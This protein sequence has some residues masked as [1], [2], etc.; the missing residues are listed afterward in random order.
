M[1]GWVGWE[2]GR[3]QSVSCQERSLNASWRAAEVRETL[4]GV[5]TN[6]NWVYVVYY[7]P[8]MQP[9]WRWHCFIQVGRVNSN[10]S[11]WKW[12]QSDFKA[13]ACTFLFRSQ[14]PNYGTTTIAKLIYQLPDGNPLQVFA[15]S[16]SRNRRVLR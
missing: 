15:P 3:K 5:V 2:K 1:F 6:T 13:K 4:S 14:F 12:P 7:S 16:K 8:D 11:H 9:H 10:N